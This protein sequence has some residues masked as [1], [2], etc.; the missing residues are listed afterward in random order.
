MKQSARP[1]QLGYGKII[2]IPARAGH[3][4][5][6]SDPIHAAIIR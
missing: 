4:A 3:H 2:L 1:D 5:V 6:G